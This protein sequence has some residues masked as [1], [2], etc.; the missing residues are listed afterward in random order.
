MTLA[1]AYSEATIYSIPEIGPTQPSLR[2]A[3]YPTPAVSQMWLAV[4]E[5]FSLKMMI[6]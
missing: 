1:Y 3:M 4:E 2:R 5:M 6:M